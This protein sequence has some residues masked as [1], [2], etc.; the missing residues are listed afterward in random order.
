MTRSKQLPI[1]EPRDDD[2]WRSGKPVEDPEKTKRWGFVTAKPSEYLV[3]VRRGRVTSSSG[4]GTTC[5]KWPWES[6]AIV[7]TSLQRLQFRAD[8]ITAERIGVE[9]VGL[10]VFRIADPQL[11]FR[12]LN[13]SYPERAQ[14]K[15]QSTLIE[16]FIGATRRIIATLSVDDCL[17]KRKQA[18]AEELLREI[19]PV[20]GGSGRPD[21]GTDRGWGVVIDTIEIQEVRVLSE[22]VFAAMQAPARA[23]LDRRAREARALADKAIAAQ[24]AGCRREIEEARIAST[25]AIDKRNAEVAREKAEAE[26]QAALAEIGRKQAFAEAQLRVHEVLVTSAAAQADSERARATHDAELAKLRTEAARIEGQWL[27]EV[28]RAKAEVAIRR[29]DAAAKV[30]TAENLPELAAAIGQVRV[31]QYG[32]DGNPFGHI[33]SAVAAVREAFGGGSDAA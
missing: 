19:A 23:A 7:P 22:K 33:A 20:V 9:V 17:G 3:H 11:A 31:V 4:Q 6:V 21:D 13:F 2:G 24:E 32:G 8:Q 27:A 14:E 15:L 26:A 5:F 25:E 29:A 12:V 1:A 16:M 10:A 30:A 28:E 18:L